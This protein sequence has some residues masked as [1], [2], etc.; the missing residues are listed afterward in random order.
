MLKSQYF[1]LASPMLLELVN[2]VF[3]VLGSLL[4]PVQL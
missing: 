1:F 3:L 2:E 4:S